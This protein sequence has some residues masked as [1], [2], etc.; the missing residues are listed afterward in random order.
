MNKTD[1]TALNN[2]VESKELNSNYGESA[3]NKP[4]ELE[5]EKEYSKIM[6]E[7]IKI[8]WKL[9]SAHQNGESYTR[10][11]FE[12]IASELEDKLKDFISSLL[13]HQKEQT[14]KDLLNDVKD[15]QDTAEDT[16]ILAFWDQVSYWLN[17]R[18]NDERSKRKVY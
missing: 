16:K 11:R 4:K 6:L 14:M 8:Q 12:K 17:S 13:L 15:H 1:N 2:G 9:E 10:M 7:W 5:W 3:I 18:L